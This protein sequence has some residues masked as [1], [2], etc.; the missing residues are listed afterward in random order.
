MTRDAHVIPTD[1][2]LGGWWADT[3][4]FPT[5]GLARGCG[6]ARWM[7]ER[8]QARFGIETP[9]LA[10]SLKRPAMDTVDNRRQGS[11]S[12]PQAVGL[13]KIFTIRG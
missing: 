13:E 9:V 6:L 5:P 3:M 11:L 4:K 8:G 7:K 12:T 1:I 10:T 2:G